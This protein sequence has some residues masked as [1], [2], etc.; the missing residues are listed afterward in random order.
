MKKLLQLLFLALLLVGCSPKSSDIPPRYLKKDEKTIPLG[1]NGETVFQN[2]LKKNARVIGQDNCYTRYGY[3]EIFFDVDKKRRRYA[4]FSVP[5]GESETFFSFEVRKRD[6]SSPNFAIRRHNKENSNVTFS[7]YRNNRWNNVS[8]GTQIIPG[9][10]G[11]YTV[12]VSGAFKKFRQEN[13][14]VISSKKPFMLSENEADLEAFFNSLSPDMVSLAEDNTAYIIAYPW[15]EIRVKIER[16]KNVNIDIGELINWANDRVFRQAIVR[17]I[18][19][20]ISERDYD[21]RIIFTNDN[22]GGKRVT[23]LDERNKEHSIASTTRLSHARVTAREN[24]ACESNYNRDFAYA[25]AHL[26]GVTL[27]E[28]ERN[29]VLDP[30]LMNSNDCGIHLSFRQWNQLHIR[31]GR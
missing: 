8:N 29:E 21:C 18:P 28:E 19:V 2:I 6:D 20:G 16:E 4:I 27:D 22:M 26:L 31:R 1:L 11:I 7:L 9:E 25:V 17:L 23:F 14:A 15:R 3:G 12:R 10:P 13:L 30:N 24:P 5:E